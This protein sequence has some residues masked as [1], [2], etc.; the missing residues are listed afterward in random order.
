MP[1]HISDGVR[2]FLDSNSNAT[3]CQHVNMFAM[4]YVKGA[5]IVSGPGI[6]SNLSSLT[7]LSSALIRN[8]T[9]LVMK[10]ECTLL[11]G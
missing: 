1:Q 9:V 3:D 5:C 2:S 10:G 7:T 11:H 8:L 6:F 4:R